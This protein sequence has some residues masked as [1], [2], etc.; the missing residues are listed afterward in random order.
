MYFQILKG[1]HAF[2]FISLKVIHHTPA[3]TLSISGLKSRVLKLSFLS[4]KM[5]VKSGSLSPFRVAAAEW[6]NWPGSLA[7]ISEGAR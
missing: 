7:G 6:P 1:S 2:L 3:N 5:M 4:L